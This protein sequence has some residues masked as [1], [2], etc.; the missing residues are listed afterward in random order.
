MKHLTYP[1]ALCLA[2][3]A[4]TA[5]AGGNERSTQSAM[6]LFEPGN[7]A[8]LSFTSVSPNVSGTGA[9]TVPNPA[10]PTP[11]QDS[12]NMAE[13][14]S[15]MGLSYKHQ[16]NERLSAA[17]IYEMPFGA[18]I[19]YPAGTTYFN[20]GAQADLNIHSLTGL[21]KYT[22]PSN[23][24]IF[25]GLR[26]QTMDATA[27]VP[28]VSNYGIVTSKDS[29]LGHV[30]GVAY[31]KP[32]IAL[33]VALTYNSQIDHTVQATETTVA[34]GTTITPE[35]FYTPESVNLEFQSGI[36]KDTLLFGSIR[37]VGWSK[38][39][40][41][42]QQYVIATGIPIVSYADDTVTYNLGLGR[43]FNENWSGAV[44]LGY[45]KSNG[46]FSANLGP[47]DG[48]WSIGLGGSYKKGNVKISAG[49]KYIH[50]G[51]A[52]TTLA[53]G[54][55]ASDFTNNHAVAAGLKIG[56]HF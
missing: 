10:Q 2:L 29:G 45:E 55:P 15:Q 13:S 20:R 37:W 53:G 8:E 21:L 51:D 50:L 54:L 31:E 34:M 1:I 27:R 9:G 49:V 12:G 33:R 36:A 32:E 38:F 5:L 14:H 17:L 42:P 43:K 22:T 19:H 23:F 56:Y 48:N 3:S 40:L 25:G 18:D 16:F 46:G 41:S 28:I 6:V 7:Y 44:T 47:V 39:D 11:G 52:Q 4:S 30:L 24:S 35:S 26:Y